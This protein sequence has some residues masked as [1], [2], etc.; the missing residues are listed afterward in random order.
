MDLHHQM[1]LLGRVRRL[2]LEAG[3]TVVAAIHGACLGGGL[4]VYVPARHQMLSFC[5]QCGKAAPIAS[6]ASQ[7]LM[8]CSA[9]SNRAVMASVPKPTLRRSW[10]MSGNIP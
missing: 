6:L 7:T 3:L 9:E 5:D 8:Y 2:N 4:D 10:N 1:S